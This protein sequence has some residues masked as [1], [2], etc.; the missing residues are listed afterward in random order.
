MKNNALVTEGS[1]ERLWLRAARVGEKYD[2]KENDR[3]RRASTKREMLVWRRYKTS[4][5]VEWEFEV[6]EKQRE[7]DRERGGKT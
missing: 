6:R 3:Q 5:D 7:E 1:R 2:E 4:L